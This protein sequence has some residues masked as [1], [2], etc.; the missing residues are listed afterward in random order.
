MDTQAVWNQLSSIPV[1]TIVA[2][3]VVISAIVS[4]IW[5]AMMKLY[6]LFS[7]YKEAKDED[8]NQ[9]KLL[10]KHDESFKKI[11][12]DITEIRGSI[13]NDKLAQHDEI[14]N[15][16]KN[17]L[18]EMRN[19]FKEQ[20]KINYE[21]LKHEIVISSQKAIERNW[22][23][24]EELQSLEEMFEEYVE[25]YHGNGYVKGLM[26]RVRN[27]PIICAIGAGE[28]GHVSSDSHT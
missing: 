22:I 28:E 21:I 15:D 1:G 16:I 27:V 8:K 24:S 18:N 3:I 20:R 13:H 9:T 14:L 4:A 7:A 12:E 5:V 19:S 25:I 10:A 17:C 2:W 6:K 26:E 11:Q 23:T